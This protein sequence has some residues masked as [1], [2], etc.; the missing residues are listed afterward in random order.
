MIKHFAQKASKYY[1]DRLIIDPSKQEIYSYGFE[2]LISTAINFIGIFLISCVFKCFFESFL[3]MAAFIPLRLTA[4]GYHAK[5]HWSC[6]LGFNLLFFL[7]MVLIFCL[8]SN[9]L[10]LYSLIATSISSVLICCLAPVEAANRPLNRKQ[11]RQQKN[12]SITL[13][14]INITIV[15][16]NSL[17]VQQFDRLLTYYSSGALCVGL[18]LIVAK[19]KNKDISS[20]HT[21]WAS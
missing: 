6:I 18:L 9:A 3:F 11:H 15:F 12:R 10:S 7:F 5:H 16:V 4:G 2:L 17:I 13:S 20:E 14:L 1:S 21:S 8:N 19:A